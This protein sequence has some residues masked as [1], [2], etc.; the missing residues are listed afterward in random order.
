MQEVYY[1][2]LA[3][4]GRGGYNGEASM[5][6]WIHGITLRRVADF[7]SGKYRSRECPIL[8]GHDFP[9]DTLSS[10]RKY[11][12]QDLKNKLVHRFGRLSPRSRQ[13]FILLLNGWEAYE[14]A[15]VLRM[16]HKTVNYHVK[17]GR[18]KLRNFL[19][20]A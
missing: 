3:T 16:S 19:V 2:S 12:V 5:K 15:W 17:Y 11:E 18:L 20:E 8:E 13:I 9:S 4:L 6:T 14:I 10:E 7:L 1:T